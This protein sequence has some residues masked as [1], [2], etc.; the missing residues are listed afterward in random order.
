MSEQQRGPEPPEPEPTPPYYQQ[1]SG[2]QPYGTPPPGG[3]GGP[4]V[5]LPGARIP[6]QIDPETG[7]PFSDKER[8]TAGLLQLVGS[9]FGFPGIGRLYAGH[10]A[11]GVIQLVGAITSIPLVLVCIGFVS[12]PAMVIWGIVDGVLMLTNKAFTDGDGRVLR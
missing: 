11:I 2:Y 6:G 5:G 1:P 7:L 8:M 3:Y 12:W 10:T 4:P 9:L